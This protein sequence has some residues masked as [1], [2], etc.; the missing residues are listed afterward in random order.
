M[1][2]CPFW[3]LKHNFV[4]KVSQNVYELGLW[5]L[6]YCFGL[7]DRWPDQLLNEIRLILMELSL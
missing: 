7:G 4:Y 3:K 6:A 1:E 2:I 5:Y